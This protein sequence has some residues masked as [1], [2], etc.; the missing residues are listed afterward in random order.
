MAISLSRSPNFGRPLR[1]TLWAVLGTLSCAVLPT[2]V[3]AEQSTTRVKIIRSETALFESGSALVGTEAKE[4]LGRLAVAARAK[5]ANVEIL[6]AV[7]HSDNLEGG[8]KESRERLSLARA[9]AAKDH[10]VKLGVLRD[11]I[12]TEGRG[13]QIPKRDN[14]TPANR[15]QNRRV[16]LE[17]VTTVDQPVQA[18]K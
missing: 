10:L 16:E 14:A 3:A 8:S 5:G 11:R 12:Y 9:E 15:A 6:V 7:G 17:L 4:K 18:A 2:F 1:R 13:D